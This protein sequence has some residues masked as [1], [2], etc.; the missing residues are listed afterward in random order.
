MIMTIIVAIPKL[1]TYDWVDAKLIGVAVGSAVAVV[2][3]VR[4]VSEYDE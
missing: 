2:V 3:A 4:C 1:K